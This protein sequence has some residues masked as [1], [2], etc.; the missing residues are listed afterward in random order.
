MAPH[1]VQRGVDSGHDRVFDETTPKNALPSGTIVLTL[2]G[3]LPVE[4]LTAGDRV[5]TRD[6]GTSV[7]RALRRHKICLP[8]VAIRGG[9][10]GHMRPEDEVILPAAQEILIRDW[11]AQALF[12]KAQALVPVSRLVDGTHI[13]ALGEQEM[14]LHEMVFDAPHI[15][16]AD[17]LELAGAVLQGAP[18]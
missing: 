12:G 2:D 10:L 9:A 18:V 3:A 15:L 16:Y 17:G 14:T 6:S 13:C 8:T 11:R 7:L 4:F 5:I 1:T